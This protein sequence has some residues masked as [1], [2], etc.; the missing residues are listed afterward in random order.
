MGSTLSTKPNRR[1]GKG[2]RFVS[3]AEVLGRYDIRRETLRNWL[4]GG[5]FPQPDLARGKRFWR[6][7]ESTLVAW[8]ARHRV[9]K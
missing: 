6:W 9:G 2:D 7:M 1:L 5:D 4:R 3:T 8:E